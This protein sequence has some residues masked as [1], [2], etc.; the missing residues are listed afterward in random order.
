MIDCCLG[1]VVYSE[2]VAR[3]L[4]LSKRVNRDGGTLL[5]RTKFRTQQ[6][7]VTIFPFSAEQ[8]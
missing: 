5:T 7:L 2:Q 3:L 1:R 6:D 4:L 8:T